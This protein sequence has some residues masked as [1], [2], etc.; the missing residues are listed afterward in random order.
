M[1]DIRVEELSSEEREYVLRAQ[2]YFEKLGGP[3][4]VPAPKVPA[5]MRISHVLHSDSHTGTDVAEAVDSALAEG[6]SWEQI[7]TV[8]GLTGD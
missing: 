5:L 1:A 3:D 7:G 2:E 8:L 6:K 4:E